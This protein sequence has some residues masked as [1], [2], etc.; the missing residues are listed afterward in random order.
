[1]TGVIKNVNKKLKKDFGGKVRIEKTKIGEM[2]D[3][4]DA[5]QLKWKL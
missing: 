1:M 5:F 3:S 2:G 4:I